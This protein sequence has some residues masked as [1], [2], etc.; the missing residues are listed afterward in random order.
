MNFLDIVLGILL[1]LGLYKGV[2]NGLFVELASLIAIVAGVY[3]AIHFS[4][5]ASD[6]ISQNIA[7]SLIHI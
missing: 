2:K 6:F 1:A 7:L 4:Y 3:G 5:I